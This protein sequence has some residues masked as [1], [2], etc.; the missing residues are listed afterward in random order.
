MLP[1]QTIFTF[2]GPL[3][4]SVFIKGKTR[5]TIPGIATKFLLIVGAASVLYHLKFVGI[6]LWKLI[7]FIRAKFSNR[8]PINKNKEAY[9]AIYGADSK[10]G[11]SAAKLFAE[12]K[13]NLILI[14]VSKSKI[15]KASEVLKSSIKN[16]GIQIDTLVINTREFE[17]EKK[18]NDTISRYFEQKKE[19]KILVN[20]M[21]ISTTSHIIKK[22]HDYTIDEVEAALESRVK[23]YLLVCKEVLTNMKEESGSIINMMEKYSK[24]KQEDPLQMATRSFIE[25]ITQTMSTNYR[26]NGISFMNIFYD[27]EKESDDAYLESLLLK[28]ISYLG[29]KNSIST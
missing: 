29:I 5:F 17:N 2:A 9:A 10:A 7:Q 14:D 25:S 28:A 24:Y 13:Y 23:C 8:I 22:I 12:K 1:K 26:N 15:D 6:G 27:P 3:D 18:Y 16:C 4:I 19:I 21:K 20:C 11:R